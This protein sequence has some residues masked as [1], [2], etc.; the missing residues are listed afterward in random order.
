MVDQFFEFVEVEHDKEAIMV[1]RQFKGHLVYWWKKLQCQRL[2]KG[3]DKIRTWKKMRREVIKEF[4]PTWYKNKEYSHYALYVES[5]SPMLHFVDNVQV[6]PSGSFEKLNR[7]FREVEKVCQDSLISQVQVDMLATSVDDSHKVVGDTKIEKV[8]INLDCNTLVEPLVRTMEESMVEK[9]RQEVSTMGDKF[10]QGE[11]FEVNVENGRQ[12][13]E[14][15]QEDLVGC[16]EHQFDNAFIEAK[17]HGPM[18]VMSYSP[19]L[20][21]TTFNAFNYEE[22]VQKSLS[23]FAIIN[24]SSSDKQDKL[25]SEEFM[26]KE[27]KWYKALVNSKV[28]C[29]S[30]SLLPWDFDELKKG[31]S[32]GVYQNHKKKTY[33]STSPTCGLLQLG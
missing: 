8:A 25:E 22:K 13:V 18:K 32:V 28:I 23:I 33:R 21:F 4:V 3:K 1:A 31:F 10:S 17:V 15:C 12:N 20:M 19:G 16:I 6:Q 29:D 14:K 5:S 24:G 26:S 9:E 11:A 2:L 30:I 27:R 7:E